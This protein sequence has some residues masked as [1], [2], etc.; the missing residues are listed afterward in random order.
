MKWR[1]SRRSSRSSSQSTTPFTM[2]TQLPSAARHDDL[3]VA[4]LAAQVDDK[5][6]ERLRR[7]TGHDVAAQ[8]VGPVVAGAPELR[9]VRLVLDRAV[10]MG[11]HRAE[12][13][14]LAF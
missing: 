6:P 8:V 10:Q 5:H 11:A 13:A 14:H 2:A 1:S 9:G 12:R 7:G 4:G 3:F